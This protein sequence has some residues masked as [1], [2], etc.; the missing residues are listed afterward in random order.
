[1]R[2]AIT[3]LCTDLNA[4]GCAAHDH[5]LDGRHDQNALVVEVGPTVPARHGGPVLSTLFEGRVLS[6]VD[7]VPRVAAIC[8]E[9]QC[10]LLDRCRHCYRPIS[11]KGLVT[12]QCEDCKTDL[13]RM[14]AVS[15]AKDALGLLSQQLIQ[16][17]LAVANALDRVSNPHLPAQPPEVLYDLLD[18]LAQRLLEGQAAWAQLPDPL[19]GLAN[20]IAA[21]ITGQ[22][23]LT[24]GQA[25]FLY[26]SAFAG[27]LNWPQGL[28]E[29][30]DA[31]CGYEPSVSPSPSR[32]DC[33]RVF[34]HAWLD[35]PGRTNRL[36]LCNPVWWTTC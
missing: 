36:N 14:R 13:R 23:S 31:Y 16:C 33:L 19:R 21:S 29:L 4:T 27:L 28:F 20:P 26:R 10:V 7:W 25:Y 5:D 11:I 17:W 35:H 6:P 30:L 15:V 22:Q 2:R 24:P 34:Q 18:N 32:I 1:M 8:L 12:Q 3:W 9:H